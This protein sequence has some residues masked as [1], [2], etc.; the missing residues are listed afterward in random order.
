MLRKSRIS[1]IGIGIGSIALLLALLHFYAGPFT[2]QPSLQDTVADTAVAIRDATVAALRG[3]EREKSLITAE[4]DLDRIVQILISVLG[5]CA[6]ILGV[7]GFASRESTRAA[8][9]AFVLGSF[10]IGFQFLGIALGAILLVI[11][12]AAVLSQLGFG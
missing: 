4:Y 3:E 8:V 7:V 9:G 11:L 12:V 2:P 6:V 5:G 10:A 1:M